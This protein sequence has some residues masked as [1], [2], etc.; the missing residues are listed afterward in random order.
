MSLPQSRPPI[1]AARRVL[2]FL[3]LLPFFLLSALPLH[4]DDLGS[5][6]ASPRVSGAHLTQAFT[7]PTF[8]TS[9]VTPTATETFPDTAETATSESGTEAATA[10]PDT[11]AATNPETE[12][13]P[14]TGTETAASP[15]AAAATV[16]T[17]VLPDTVANTAATEEQPESEAVGGTDAGTAGTDVLPEAAKASPE[18]EA[19]QVEVDILPTLPDS[20]SVAAEAEAGAESGAVPVE[21][22]AESAPEAENTTEAA[23]KTPSEIPGAAETVAAEAADGAAQPVFHPLELTEIST[24]DLPEPLDLTVPTRDLWERVRNGFAMPDLKD[25]LVLV[26]QQYYL[27]HPD[28]LR[29][30]VERSSRYLHHIVEELEKRD[31]P[32]ELALLPMVESAYNPMAISSARASGLWQFMPSTGLQY[33]LQQNWWRDQRRD[34]IA[35]TSAALD[36]LQ[37]IYEMHGDWHLALASYNWGEGAVGRAI[38]KNEAK[39]LPGGY[40]DLSMPNE[41]RHYVPKL[42]ALKNIFS[43]PLL[44]AELGIPA[45]PNTPYFQTLITEVPIDIKLAARFAG[46][47]EAEFVALNP[48]HNRPVI[49]ADSTLVIPAGKVEQFKANLA[50]HDAPLSTWRSYNLRRGEKLE[51]LAPRFGI[52][53]ADLKRVNGLKGRIKLK[54]GHTLIVPTTASASLRLPEDEKP[55][56]ERK[57]LTIAPPLPATDAAPRAAARTYRVKQGDTLFAIAR[58]QNVR[59]ADLKRLNQIKGDAIRPGLRLVLAPG[60]AVN[61]AEAPKAAVVKTK[62]PR[63]AKASQAEKTAAS[64]D[65]TKTAKTAKSTQTAKASRITR[66]TVQ[67]GDTLF[68]IARRYRV[69]LADLKRWNRLSSNQIRV[70]T[71]LQIQLNG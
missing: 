46:L 69:A 30:M 34:I 67:K 51:Q 54:P 12:V 4:A 21:D 57:M 32:T 22:V 35:S 27:S 52:T 13:L 17:A 45:I 2:R 38:A 3:P 8:L 68:S 29:R 47:S 14:D 58:K 56:D 1:L 50:A 16:E 28:Y 15:D 19:A 61:V 36:Y 49:Q 71:T 53:L 60:Q 23:T 33:K 11:A 70:G 9:P 44:L 64:A 59:V 41:T 37:Y 42:Q 26:H 7:L 66:H 5:G 43:N 25:D 55:A 10:S 63:V 31:M 65:T 39:G 40:T 18:V 20:A 6:D 24:F 48:A 62:A